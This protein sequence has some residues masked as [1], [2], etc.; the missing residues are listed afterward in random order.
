ML[1]KLLL[2]LSVLLFTAFAWAVDVNTASQAELEAIKGI[3][4]KTAEAIITE[5]K[6]GGVFKNTQDLVTRVK[7]I[8]D[9]NVEKFKAEGLT[10]AGEKGSAAKQET[11]KA[12]AKKESKKD[13][14]KADKKEAVKEEKAEAKKTSKKEA[15]KDE[16]PAAKDE[17]KEA[18]K[19][20][21]ESK[22]DSKGDK[23]DDKKK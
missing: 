15:V 5:R 9:T 4:P 22:E 18:K 16:K 8:G 20:K 11:K 19:S 2:A 10:I 6:K 21:K 14:A 7:G 17:K 3:G 12:E 13:E 1:K 23:K